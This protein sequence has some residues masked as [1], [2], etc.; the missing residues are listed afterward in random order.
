FSST[1]RSTLEVNYRA[2]IFNFREDLIFANRQ[3]FARNSSRE[4]FVQYVNTTKAIIDSRKLK[5][6]NN[7]RFSALAR[8]AKIWASEN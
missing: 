5:P 2:A 4:Q 8:F 1:R 7:L 3:R 6:A